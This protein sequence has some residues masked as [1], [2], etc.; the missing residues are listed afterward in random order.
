FPTTRPNNLKASFGGTTPDFMLKL[1]F[2]VCFFF[3]HALCRSFSAKGKPPCFIDLVPRVPTGL[4]F[5][6]IRKTIGRVSAGDGDCSNLPSLCRK[7]APSSPVVD[8]RIMWLA[9]FGRLGLHGQIGLGDDIAGDE[10]GLQHERRLLARFK[11]RPT[12]P[13]PRSL[14]GIPGIA[15]ISI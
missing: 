8:V 9:P 4:I 5:L 12:K 13:R 7:R 10:A 1:E 3:G 2:F 15:G 6:E 11:P 14:A